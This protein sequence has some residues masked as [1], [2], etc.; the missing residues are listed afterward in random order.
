MDDWGKA[1]LPDTV[2]RG[3]RKSTAALIKYMDVEQL[4]RG[5]ANAYT[6]RCVH[7]MIQ[8]KT[9]VFFK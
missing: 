8:T 9:R 2:V 4:K 3:L 1:F 6:G 5:Y 7:R